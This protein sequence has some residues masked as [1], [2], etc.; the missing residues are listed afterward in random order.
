MRISEKRRALL[1]S[2]LVLVGLCCGYACSPSSGARP[3]N[4]GGSGGQGA[5]ANGTYN[6]GAGTGMVGGSAGSGDSTGNSG[7]LFSRDAGITQR[8]SGDGSCGAVKQKPEQ[9]IVYQDASYTDT[10]T[11]YSPVALYIMQDDS[12]SMVTGFP[13]GSAQSWGDATAAISAFVNDPASQDLDVGLAFFP[14]P[15]NGFGGD[16]TAG[17]DCGTPMV[18]I[19]KVSSNKS[20]LVAAMQNNPPGVI[21][22]TPTECG[23]RGMIQ[24]C[25]DY[26]ARSG[27]QCV[28]VLVTDGAPTVCDTNAQNLVNIVAAGKSS[29]VLTFTLGLNGSDIQ[30]LNQ[31]AQAGGTSAA[32]DATNTSTSQQNFIGA[33]N[34]IRSKVTKSQTTHHTTQ[35]TVAT[36]LDCQWKVP[37]PP[38]GETLD[39]NK[40]NL[41]L[42]PS[43]SAAQSIGHV[44]DSSQCASVKDGWYYDNNQ[45]P[46]QVFVCPQ[47]CSTIKA[48]TAIEVQIL[49]NC[50]TI[51]ARPA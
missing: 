32:I 39:P 42:T 35:H 33:L 51:E 21:N 3:Q 14:P 13:T 11:T 34:A 10:I 31:L 30:F 7:L 6:A 4:L 27:E 37:A 16:C 1:T 36:Q 47:T 20:Q 49:F 26:T 45:S 46:T 29:G 8:S 9:I 2:A 24:H 18:E 44:G 38:N 17:T 40:V 22:L 5:A 41:Q 28:A 23:L 25:V 12:G 48:S 43:G 15:T 50:A 19:G